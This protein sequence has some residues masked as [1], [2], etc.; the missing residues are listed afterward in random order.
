M[1]DFEKRTELELHF[2][3]LM[4]EIGEPFDEQTLEQPGHLIEEFRDG[5]RN[6]DAYASNDEEKELARKFVE[7]VT[8]D[9]DGQYEYRSDD[10]IN[11][12]KPAVLRFG[13]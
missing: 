7:I 4:Q 13:L 3:Q 12:I 11:I 6:E 8:K 9:I 1:I 2:I 5:Y 10:F